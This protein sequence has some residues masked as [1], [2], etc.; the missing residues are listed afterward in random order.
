M[1]YFNNNDVAIHFETQGLKADHPK[2]VIVF[3]N[4]LGTDLRIWDDVRDELAPD[5]VLITYDKRGHGLSDIGSTPYAIADHVNDLAAL[6]D[7]LHQTQ[8]IVV[9]LSVGGLIAQGLQVARPDLVKALVLSNTAHKI[10][11]PDSWN[12]RIA[13]IEANGLASILEPVMERWFTPAFRQ[14][15]SPAYRGYCNM[16]T[17]QPVA[18]YIATCAAIRDADFTQAAQR[19]T[20]PTLC[21]A[22][23]KDGSTPAELVRSLADLIP[24]A[25]FAVVSDAGHLPCIEQPA[26]YARL[27]RDFIARF[28]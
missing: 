12:S 2:P 18:G 23:D 25:G 13:A 3:I 16:F 9:G 22:G 21:I 1:P 28:A 4:S 27:L 26:A 20:A 7:H 17:R 24:Q 19:I 15:E 14:P 8:V 10:G 11:T 6:L 5:H